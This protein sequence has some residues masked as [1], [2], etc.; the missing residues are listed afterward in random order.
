MGAFEPN[1][2]KAEMYRLISEGLLTLRDARDMSFGD[3]RD[4]LRA[5]YIRLALEGRV[6]LHNVPNPTG[7][8][9]Q[10]IRAAFG[11]PPE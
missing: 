10:R 7:T 1:P 6:T 11:L 5:Y 4:H 3:L 9:S 2:Y 8:L